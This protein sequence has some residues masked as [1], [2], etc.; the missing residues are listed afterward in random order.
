MLH[1]VHF[2]YVPNTASTNRL[3]SYLRNIPKHI[4]VSL[5]FLMP[6]PDNSEVDDLPKNIHVMYCWK[7]FKASCR[8]FI[9]LTYY[10][11]LL[12]IRRRLKRGDVVYAYNIPHYLTFL[13]KKGIRYYGER[14]ESP[15]VTTSP[16]RLVPFSLEKHLNLCHK[17][18]GIFVISTALRDYYISK[19]VS[20]E[21]IHIINITVEQSRFLGLSRSSSL[22]RYIA[23]CGTIS[24]T[25]DGLDKL[26]LSFAL[27]NK[28]FPNIYLYI[29]GQGSS[30]TKNSN[31]SLIHELGISDKVIFT[32]K[33]TSERI[34]Q[35][36]IDAE[37]CVLAR[38]DS[39]QS[40]CGFPTKLGEYLL[41]GN[42][43]VVTDVGD[44]PLFLEDNVSAL[45]ASSNDNIEF[46]SKMRWV[47]ENP[48]EAKIIGKRGYEVALKYFNAKFEV[49]KMLSIMHLMHSF[50]KM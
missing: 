4:E 2:S 50:D 43:V 39:L 34:P 46:A 16:S 13:F 30:E 41:S 9:P 37:M 32:G 48:D 3:L 8:I 49:S 36:L 23:Y 42:P 12:Y 29:I 17:L 21:K 40:K 47:L 14:T 33:V 19:G 6:S 7:V 25:K 5:Y 38:P 45:I 1:I 44:I 24:N 31:L 10:L 28:D 35:M 20:K 26:I 11:S 27:I 22:R 18:D 15:E